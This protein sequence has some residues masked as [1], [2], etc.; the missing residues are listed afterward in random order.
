MSALS[1]ST[2]EN[3]WVATGLPTTIVLFNQLSSIIGTFPLL[4]RQFPDDGLAVIEDLLTGAEI[5]FDLMQDVTYSRCAHFYN[6][7]P[8]WS[9][10]HAG[11]V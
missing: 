10:I 9:C 2:I 8:L 3:F 1:E 7:S 11:M 6:F 5:E 4:N